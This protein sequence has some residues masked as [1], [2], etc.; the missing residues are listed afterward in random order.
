MATAGQGNK[1]SLILK[2]A[3]FA[4]LSHE[5]Q[6]RKFSSPKKP[7]YTHVAAVAGRVA[8]WATQDEVVAAAFLHDTLEDCPRV[9]YD[10][11]TIE[12]GGVVANFVQWLTNP[13]KGS[14][15]PRAVRKKMD[16]DHIAATPAVIKHIKLE[17]RVHNLEELSTSP[18]KDFIHL[19]CRES[20][21]LIKIVGNTDPNL[22]SYALALIKELTDGAV[23]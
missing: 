11:L 1:M 3:N 15:E 2:A 6:F 12:F 20:L 4:R 21:E 19:Y 7:Y 10:L 8:G 17:D 22:E 14:K 18:E 9:T 16:R 23:T 13:S 5:G